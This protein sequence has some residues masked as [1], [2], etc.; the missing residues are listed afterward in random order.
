MRRYATRM[1]LRFPPALKR[2]AKFNRRYASKHLAILCEHKS[3]ISGVYLKRTDCKSE[4]GNQQ[5]A[6][7]YDLSTF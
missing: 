6:M 4:I 1:V 3:R 7:I 5:S 2:R